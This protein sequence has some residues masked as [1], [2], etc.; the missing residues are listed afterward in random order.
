MQFSSTTNLLNI[1]N[2]TIKLCEWTFMICYQWHYDIGK[3]VC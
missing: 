2:C 1:N 3:T